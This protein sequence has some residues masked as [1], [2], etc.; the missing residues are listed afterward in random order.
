MFEA[1]RFRQNVPRPAWARSGGP[2]PWAGGAR[3][4]LTLDRTRQLLAERLSPPAGLDEPARAAVLVALFGAGHRGRAAVLLI[5]RSV[6]LAANPGEIAFPGGRLEEGESPEE[7]ALREAEEEVGLP[8]AS[9]EVLGR[10]PTLARLR[11]PGAIV[12]VVAVVPA[13]PDLVASKGEVEEMI[14]VAL[15][16][17]LAD[18]VYWEE[19]WSPEGAPALALPFYAGTAGLG[20]DLIWG[21]TA[22]ML[23]DL[24]VLLTRAEG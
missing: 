13:M 16:D 20:D 17:L 24:L 15:D 21:A 5:R 18:G 7:A 2:A 9:V 11:L 14:P 10:L 12:P 8:P 1:R 22:R 23:T 3:L 6:E 4:A 19:L